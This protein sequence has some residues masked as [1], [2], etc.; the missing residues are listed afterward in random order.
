MCP[1][2]GFIAGKPSSV[3]GCGG[4]I[5]LASCF[6]RDLLGQGSG[7]QTMSRSG[8]CS[9]AWKE[10]V[11][12]TGLQWNRSVALGPSR[13]AESHRAPPPSTRCWLLCV[14]PDTEMGTV[15]NRGC[16]SDSPRATESQG[17]AEDSSTNL[18]ALA[19]K[20]CGWRP[21]GRTPTA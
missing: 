16:G 17:A 8:A 10:K 4:D 7:P 2:R 15:V 11:R 14:C 19:Q 18:A 20:P 21:F 6:S 12:E 9:G 13:A 3:D 5:I 1:G